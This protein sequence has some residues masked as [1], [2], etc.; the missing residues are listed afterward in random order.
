M[1]RYSDILYS[2][3]KFIHEK[4]EVA[5]NLHINYKN[6]LDSDVLEG[7]V[8]EVVYVFM[9]NLVSPYQ[10]IRSGANVRFGVYTSVAKDPTKRRAYAIVDT[11]REEIDSIATIPFYDFSEVVS[12]NDAPVDTG[13]TIPFVWFE[14]IPVTLTNADACNIMYID[15]KLFVSELCLEMDRDAAAHSFGENVQV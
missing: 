9:L 6:A 8:D 10:Y 3:H 12:A 2:V 15:Y 7:A 5:H 14:T 4:I 1:I 11:I 13:K